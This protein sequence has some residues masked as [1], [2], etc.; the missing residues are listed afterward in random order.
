MN[1]IIP[2]TDCRSRTLNTCKGWC[3]GEGATINAEAMEAT[4]AAI[5]Q[6]LRKELNP[7]G[8][9]GQ[10]IAALLPGHQVYPALKAMRKEKTLRATDYPRDMC[11]YYSLPTGTSPHAA[12]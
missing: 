4:Q 9:A 3:N 8:L 2:C 6:L 5:V 7:A 11:T 12:K 10:R 1:V